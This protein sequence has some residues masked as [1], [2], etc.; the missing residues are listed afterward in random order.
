MTIANIKCKLGNEN[1]MLDA[2]YN[3][4]NAI[5]NDLVFNEY[6]KLSFYCICNLSGRYT[7][8]LYG[9]HIYDRRNVKLP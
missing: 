3:D 8:Y 5:Y 4:I 7:W 2:M 1:E 6:T 9:L